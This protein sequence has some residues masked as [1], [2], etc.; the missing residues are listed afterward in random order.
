MLLSGCC[1]SVCLSVSQF[2]VNCSHAGR[3]P[4]NQRSDTC[5]RR[6]RLSVL[7]LAE[8]NVTVICSS[9]YTSE[10]PQNDDTHTA[11]K[12]T[13]IHPLPYNLQQSTNVRWCKWRCIV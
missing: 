4:V 13:L 5:R 6:V 10:T 8:M 11:L 7:L 9:H 3:Q 1:L 12:T 2:S